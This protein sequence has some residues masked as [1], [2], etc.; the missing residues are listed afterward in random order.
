MA[1]SWFDV[2]SFGRPCQRPN[3]RRTRWATLRERSQ[4]VGQCCETALQRAEP[5]MPG[6]AA[7][8][9]GP[10]CACRSAS[11]TLAPG[12][13]AARN[14]PTAPTAPSTP[15]AAAAGTTPG[16]RSSLPPCCSLP[17]PRKPGTSRAAPP[18]PRPGAC[19]PRCRRPGRRRSAPTG[20][21]ARRCASRRTPSLRIA[22]R[23]FD[24]PAPLRCAGARHQFIR[25][26]AEGL[27]EGQLPA[28]AGAA[29]ARLGLPASG[30]VTQRITCANGGFDLHH[31]GAGRAWLGLDGRV[32]AWQRSAAA[33]SP[34]ATVQ[35]LLL[36]HFA[37]DM[38]WT[39]AAIE[40]RSPW[41]ARA[42]ADRL[43]HWLDMAGRADEPPEFNGDPLTDSQE[44][45]ES[46]TL[47]AAR[48]RGDR[49]EV[50]V[51]YS[52][53]GPAQWQVTLLLRRLDGRWLVDGVRLRDGTP[54]VA[55]LPTR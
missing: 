55:L 28:P 16:A 18:P 47:A 8:P 15:T 6:I 12:A 9:P 54:L 21:P 3:N 20:R 17:P 49:A 2:H 26:P 24:G 35:A 48:V 22:A 10:P 14:A 34:E 53:P 13:Q 52:G 5:T 42:F 29:A 44:A 30:G 23:S 51:R 45:P 37:G 4:H 38:A 31:D 25:L 7:L 11:A 36:Q 43:R 50:Q 27:F 32:L 41:M 33:T 39:P 1:G 46:F 40:A 19:R